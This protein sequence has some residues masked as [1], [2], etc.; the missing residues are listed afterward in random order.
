[1]AERNWKSVQ[2]E[3]RRG[4]LSA[5]VTIQIETWPLRGR[6]NGVVLLNCLG[7]VDALLATGCLTPS[8]MEN[9]N[10]RRRGGRSQRDEHGMWFT[11]H[12]SP[13]KSSPDRMKLERCP[14]AATVMR[15]PGVRE[16]FPQG[17]P[18]PAQAEPQS[19][20]ERIC[21]VGKALTFVQGATTWLGDKDKVLL[22]D[23]DLERAGSIVDKFLADM[24]AAMEEAAVIDTAPKVSPHQ[25]GPRI[26]AHADTNGIPPPRGN[27]RPLNDRNPARVASDRRGSQ[28]N[29][30]K[31]LTYLVH[32]TGRICAI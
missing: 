3:V 19:K 29:L 10:A 5:G 23:I 17:I 12:R 2:G 7:T 18:N 28:K 21:L 16:L 14:D 11:L 32:R 22:S 8:M 24:R 4:S 20:E 31:R 15:L 6:V 30:G 13:T 25:R 1:M 27:R 26:Q 9:R